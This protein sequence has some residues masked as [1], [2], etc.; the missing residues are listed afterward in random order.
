MTDQK[1]FVELEAEKRDISNILID[2]D[3]VYSRPSHSRPPVTFSGRSA[4]GWRTGGEAF[5]ISY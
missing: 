5:G 1:A 4:S 2:T 3:F